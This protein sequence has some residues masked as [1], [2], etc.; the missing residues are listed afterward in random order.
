MKK[1]SLP[2]EE[3]EFISMER[4]YEKISNYDR[5]VYEQAIVDKE[6]RDTLKRKVTLYRDAIID[7]Y[8]FIRRNVEEVFYYICT[9]HHNSIN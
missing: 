9:N 6:G 8:K 4:A 1:T 2:Q 3:V 5:Y 7:G